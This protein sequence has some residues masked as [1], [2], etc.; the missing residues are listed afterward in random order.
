MMLLRGMS[1][2]GAIIFFHLWH[3]ILFS[4]DTYTRR[5]RMW[6][7]L[8]CIFGEGKRNVFS[9]FAFTSFYCFGSKISVDMRCMWR[10]GGR[11]LNSLFFPFFLS[12]VS[13]S[14][15]FFRTKWAM[16]S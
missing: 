9:L 14:F 8:P 15:V 7:T 11:Y 3:A 6:F 13:F 10:A 2:S 4:F 16:G 12:V 1:W 5:L